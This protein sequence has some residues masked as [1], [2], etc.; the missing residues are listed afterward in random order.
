MPYADPAKKAANY[1][2][3]YQANKEKRKAYFRARYWAEREDIRRYQN[4]L[5]EIKRSKVSEDNIRST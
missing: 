1:A 2:A 4:L 5:R 3:Y